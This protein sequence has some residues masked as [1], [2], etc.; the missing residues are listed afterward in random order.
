MKIQVQYFNLVFLVS[1]FIFNSCSV[2]ENASKHG[3][4][5]GYYEMK[6]GGDPIQKVYL[7]VGDEEIT[8]Y[9]DN[10]V[11]LGSPVSQIP[12]SSSDSIYIFPEKFI[13]KSIDLDI[14]TI[15]LKLRPSVNDLPMQM[16]IDFNAALYLGWRHDSYQVNSIVTPLKKCNHN[17]VSMGYDF[18]IFT[19]LGSTLLSPFTTNDAISYEYS[20]LI[21]QYGVA[22]FIESTV[23]SFGLAVGYDYLVSPDRSIWI[24]NKKPWV[25]LIIGFPLN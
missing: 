8:I 17:I 21:I 6:S 4:E 9:P 5:S 22:G 10:G 1:I 2:I 12:L 23:A 16:N 20:G 11:D 25:G 15:P 14:T 3:L 24:Y 7:D 19:G 18:G 13:K